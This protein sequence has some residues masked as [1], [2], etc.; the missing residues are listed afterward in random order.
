[1]NCVFDNIRKLLKVLWTLADIPQKMFVNIYDHSLNSTER[2]EISSEWGKMRTGN[3]QFRV[4][5]WKTGG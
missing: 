4:T 1:M 2:R 3:S 5:Y